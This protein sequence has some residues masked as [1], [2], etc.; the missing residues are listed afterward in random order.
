MSSE[1]VIYEVNLSVPASR[2]VEF[3]EWLQAHITEMLALPGFISASTLT[4]KEPADEGRIERSVQYRLADQP[5]LDA[6]LENDATRMRAFGIERFGDDL[7]ATRRI[8]SPVADASTIVCRN[9]QL[10]ATGQFCV[11]CGQRHKSRVLSVWAL[12]R[13]L[14]GDIL[15]WDARIW[16]TLRPLLAKPGFLTV[17]YLNGRRTRYTPPLRLYFALSIFL[18]LIT[19]GVDVGFDDSILT[20]DEEAAAEVQAALREAGIETAAPPQDGIEPA[21]PP[22]GDEADEPAVQGDEDSGGSFRDFD[23]TRI[24]EEVEMTGLPREMIVPRMVRSCQLLQTPGGLRIMIESFLEKIPALLIVL[25]PLIA[26]FNRVLHLFSRR[27]YVEHLLFFTHYQAFVFLWLI[28]VTL[29]GRAGPIASVF[30][31]L[32]DLTGLLG[33]LYSVFYLHRSLRKV[34]GLGRGLALLNLGALMFL[35]L[36][37]AL[38]LFVSAVILTAFDF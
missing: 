9:C 31:A 6:Y 24:A 21:A 13:E 30:E 34:F 1:N 29:L 15:N 35:Y 19:P 12:L 3:D 33:F 16:R 22:A 20:G 26:L 38:V 7:N 36:I 14:V 2:E 4:G 25:V 5:S 11:N 18:F 32:A 8:L 28:I 27:F 10:P 17:E 23:C 37:S